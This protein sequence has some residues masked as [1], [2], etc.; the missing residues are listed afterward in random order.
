MTFLLTLL[1]RLLTMSLTAGFVAVIVLLLR[2]VLKKRAPK[3]VICLLW[4]VVFARLLV[5]VAVETPFSL[6]PSGLDA[7]VAEQ[8]EGTAEVPDEPAAAP[9]PPSDPIQTPVVQA[10]EVQG[11]QFRTQR[12]YPHSRCPQLLSAVGPSLP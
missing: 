3:Q 4:L 5:P 11:P 7:F 10:P 1:E 9:E 2:L 8:M 12:L 6:V